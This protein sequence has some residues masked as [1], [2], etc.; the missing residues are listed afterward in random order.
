LIGCA[1]LGAVALTR[2]GTRPYPL[3]IDPGGKI[4]IVIDAPPGDKLR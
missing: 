4:D 1:G 3:G 2:F